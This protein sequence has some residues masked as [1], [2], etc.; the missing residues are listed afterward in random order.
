MD[1]N[2]FFEPSNEAVVNY[3]SNPFRQTLGDTI[4]AHTEEKGMPSIE[5]ARVVLIGVDECRG[6]VDNGMARQAPDHIRHY[7]YRL[8]IPDN[9][10]RMVDL[11]N[12]VPG[13]TTADTYAALTEVAATLLANHMTL[14]VLGGG[15]DLTFSLYKAYEQIGRII[16]IGSIDS[17]FNLEGGEAINSRNYLQHIILQQPNFLFDYINIGY[18]T[19]LVGHDMTR[20]MDELKFSPHRVGELQADIERTEPLVRYCDLV[21]VDISA[22]RQSDAPANANPSPHGFYGEQLCQIM[23]YAGMSDK[24]SCMAILEHHP[25]LDRDGQTANMLAQ[26][27]WFFLEG[28]CHRQNDFP[29]DAPQ[30]YKRFIVELSDHGMEVVFYKSMKTDRWWM[31]VPC[32]DADRQQR[33][34]RH[35]LVPC[36]YSDYTRAMENEIPD[37]WWHYYNRING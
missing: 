22:V 32:D 26:A 12:L 20:L 30:H 37:L 3:Q 14:V 29:Y 10:L 27:V 33:Y 24:T 4:A 11:G 28:L 17:T 23:R 36:N 2:G 19:Y 8:A 5:G 6:S 18:Q 21:S 13:A 9:D 31:E 7:L 16:N 35:A 15:D 34:R 1:I 25:T